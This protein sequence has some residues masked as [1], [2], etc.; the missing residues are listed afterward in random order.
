MNIIEYE[1]DDDLGDCMKD[2]C[3]LGCICDSL[4][5]KQIAPAH[6][7]K[8][9]CMFSCCCSKEA[10]KYSSCGSR[11]VNISAAVGARIM[12][13][14]QRGMAAEERK[15]S[16]TVVV[17]ADKNTVML[18]GRGSRRE[19][20]VP[21]RYKNENTLML[22]FAG[23]DYV[24][25]EE[26]SESEDES[27]EESPADHYEKLQRSADL[28]PC[29][30]IVPLVNL[31]KSCA[32]WCLYHAQYSCPCSKYKNPL[33]FAPDIETGARGFHGKNMKTEGEEKES[34]RKLKVSDEKQ[35]MA[36][37]KKKSGGEVPL[38]GIED[39]DPDFQAESSVSSSVR[40]P[41]STQAADRLKAQSARTKPLTKKQTIKAPVSLVKARRKPARNPKIPDLVNLVGEDDGEEELEVSDELNFD[42][43]QAG[44]CQ[45]VR[46]DILKE[47]YQAGFID[48]YF[49]V[50]PGRG[51]N[52][53]FLTKAGERPYIATAVNLRNLQGCT[54][55]LPSLVT[56][57]VA[58][59][60][61]RDKAR[62]CVLQ[63]NGTVWTVRSLKAIKGQKDLGLT[64]E[65]EST[66]EKDIKPE[67]EKTASVPP[68]KDGAI[69][70]NLSEPVQKLP[71]GQ[72]LITV[73][74]GPNQKA[75]MQVKLPPTLTNQYWSLISVGEGQ[76]SIQCPD[77]SLGLKC[78]ILQQAASLS[79]AT[80]TTV[81]IPIPVSDQDPSF[82]VYAVPGLKTHV[83]VGPFAGASTEVAAEDDD[84][85]CLD[86]EVE[87]V[88]ILEPNKDESSEGLEEKDEEQE[89]KELVS[90]IPLVIENGD[91]SEYVDIGEDTDN[92]DEQS[93][94]TQANELRNLVTRA[95][96]SEM[97]D[98]SSQYGRVV[99][100]QSKRRESGD[101]QIEIKYKSADVGEDQTYS[102]VTRCRGKVILVH[103]SYSDHEVICSD[104]QSATL[105]L[106]EYFANQQEE[107]DIFDDPTPLPSEPPRVR[108]PPPILKKINAPFLSA[109]KS[110][111]KMALY[112]QLKQQ[113]DEAQLFYELGHTAFDKFFNRNVTRAQILLK[114]KE[115][116]KRLQD[117]G[118]G[119]EKRK[120]ELMRRRSKLF[121]LFTKSL[122][123]L[124]ITRK[125][126][127]VI[128]LKEIL[129][130]DKERKEKKKSF[131]ETVEI[132][133][134]VKAK[135]KEKTVRTP[136]EVPVPVPASRDDVAFNTWS[137]ERRAGLLG[138]GLTAEQV[139]Q[140][141]IIGLLR[142]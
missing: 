62:Y 51:R 138:H 84:I 85:V 39:I 65:T 38:L 93:E 3:K 20:K 70:I 30:V 76:S 80:A 131:D 18:G 24:Q 81:R 63:Y 73:V 82:G 106:E 45:Y 117:E 108:S 69:K 133:K 127:A 134:K 37:K 111:N 74:E 29:T 137:A 54:Q 135:E 94:N 28:I 118:N 34:K 103:P 23:K 139:N 32:V 121:E 15:F 64:T 98:Q 107:S 49:W 110:N 67:V 14:T 16:N 8:V 114:S 124:P 87:E 11:R 101:A 68:A 90:Q 77:S 55:K 66:P 104:L 35:R 13:D 52:M 116:I 31:P 9:D 4:R 129:R 113:K 40:H 60:R 99:L 122:N 61:E 102:A 10:L 19:R 25:K 6:C 58:S 48:F 115:E 27:E 21:Q 71:I 112:V 100:R 96:G 142:V 83:F 46:W 33:D 42:L 7:G 79:T 78:A 12:E 128:E 95:S 56:D 109:G 59:I 2:Y 1:D 97:S 120:Q 140:V 22:D 5:T 43:S 72:S 41:L 17:T 53:L 119:L 89:S 132:V 126:S 125:K 130:K 141:N 36:G 75:I 105:W 86:D 92:I 91:S 57:A 50:R 88:K 26:S 47:K 136:A 123:G 44:S